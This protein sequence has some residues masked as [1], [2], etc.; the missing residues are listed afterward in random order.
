[1]SVAVAR[2]LQAEACP[3]H[4]TWLIDRCTRAAVRARE[5]CQLVLQATTTD[6]TAT[7]GLEVALDLAARLRSPRDPTASTV[8]E[9]TDISEIRDLEVG[10]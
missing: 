7:D 8:L 5:T 1:M 9:T 2:R 10:S 4:E 3:D 6:S